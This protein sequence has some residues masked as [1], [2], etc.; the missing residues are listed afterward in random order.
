MPLSSYVQQLLERA[1]AILLISDEDI[2]YKGIAAGVTERLMALKE[3]EARLRRHYNSLEDL[4]RK[5]QTEG[6]SPDDHALYTDLLEWRAINHELTQ[7]LYIFE[8]LRWYG[9]SLSFGGW[10]PAACSTK[11]A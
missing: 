2:V 1:T 10:K 9:I 4:E 3:A 5:F 8:A 11:S 7:F 6:V